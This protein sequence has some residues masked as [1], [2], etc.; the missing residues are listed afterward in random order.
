[1]DLLTKGRGE[2]IRNLELNFKEKNN[3]EI[4]LLKNELMILRGTINGEN[5]NESS[6]EGTMDEESMNEIN[7]KLILAIIEINNLKGIVEELKM[8]SSPSLFLQSYSAS[9]SLSTGIIG[10]ISAYMFCYF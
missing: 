7:S 8:C 9:T 3:H 5:Y 6:G 2:M 4:L 1:V 10:T